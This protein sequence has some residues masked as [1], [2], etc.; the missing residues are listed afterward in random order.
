[1]SSSIHSISA[2][3]IH[4]RSSK[5]IQNQMPEQLHT[6]PEFHIT[7]NHLNQNCTGNYH[8]IKQRNQEINKQCNQPKIPKKLLHINLGSTIIA[9]QQVQPQLSKASIS[10]NRLFIIPLKTLK[11]KIHATQ[12][13]TWISKLQERN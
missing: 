13:L 4:I 7:P 9:P 3:A 8:Q 6:R 11:K 10:S 5:F 12:G 2:Q 1:M